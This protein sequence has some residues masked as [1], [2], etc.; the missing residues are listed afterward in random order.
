M[1]V[2]DPVSDLLTRI[3]NAGTA[4]H[5]TTTAPYSKLRMAIAQILKEQ[6]FIAD[7]E[8]VDE[9]PQGTL[10]VTLRY[11]KNAPV[12]KQMVKVSTPGRRFYAPVDKLPRVNNGLGVAIISTSK[13]VMT[14]KRARKENVGGEVLCTIW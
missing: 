3:R 4:K 7:C 13:G 9:G 5:K 12:I 11:F 6:G 14:D 1:P 10:K 2:S 8:K